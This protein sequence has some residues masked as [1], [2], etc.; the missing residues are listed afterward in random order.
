MVEEVAEGEDLDPENIMERFNKL[1]EKNTLEKGGSFYLQSKIYFAK[2]HLMA[3]FPADLNQSPYNPD[4]SAAEEESA[5]E[6]AEEAAAE[7]KEQS[8]EKEHK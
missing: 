1:M 8:K 7:A 2:E 5:K 6:E 4:A 3:D